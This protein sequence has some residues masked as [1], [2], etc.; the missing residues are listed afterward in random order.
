MVFARGG[1]HDWAGDV[2]ELTRSFAAAG[3][4]EVVLERENDLAGFVRFVAEE[5]PKK[6]RPLVE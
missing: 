5:V 6:V 3:A 4:T 2:A 1:E